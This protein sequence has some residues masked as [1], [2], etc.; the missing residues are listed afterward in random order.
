MHY[1]SCHIPGVLLI[2]LDTISDERGFFARIFC[3]ED[4]AQQ[5]AELTPV[6]ANLSYNHKRGT[7]RGLHYQVAP[8]EEAKLVRATRGSIY[9]VAVDLRPASP[10]F[11]STY[12]VTLS[13][14]NRLA[15]FVP[16]GCAH[17]YQT[18][19]DE[20]EV[21]YLVDAPYAPQAGRGVAWNSPRLNIDWPILPPPILSAQD[22]SWPE[23][24]F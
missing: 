2:S 8:Y 21:L 22:A 24:N 15:L 3:Q 1:Q 10:A 14:E 6:Q 12:A 5:G 11:G 4:F 18:L 19:E 13:A 17:G 16:K 9:D 20:T 7:L 23:D